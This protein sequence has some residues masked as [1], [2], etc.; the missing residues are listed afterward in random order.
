MTVFSRMSVC[1]I[2]RH[3]LIRDMLVRYTKWINTACQ[4][5]E[6]CFTFKSTREQG[7]SL[8]RRLKLRCVLLVETQKWQLNSLI[9]GKRKD[10]DCV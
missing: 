2:K 4:K 7:L 8:T 9:F 1:I 10:A 6:I 3:I 5:V